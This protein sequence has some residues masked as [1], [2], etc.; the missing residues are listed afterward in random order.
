MEKIYR[1]YK[2][3]G[4][5]KSKDIVDAIMHNDCYYV[6]NYYEKGNDILQRDQ[7]GDTY[8]HI[9]SRNDYFEVID[10]L[11]KLGCDVN[12][13]NNQ[14]ETPLHLATQFNN[15]EA[16]QK[17]LL[18][19]ANPN[20][21]DK[22]G[23]SPLHIAASRG[24]VN[25]LILLLDAGAK[26]NIS[27]S[28]GAKPIHYAVKSG[29]TDMIRHL[30]SS[31]ASLVD[32]DDRKNTVLHYACETNNLNLVN[33]I[34]RHM[35]VNNFKNIYKET[36]VHF[37]ARHGNIEILRNLLN[38]GYDLEARNYLGQSPLDIANITNQENYSFLRRVISG[39]EYKEKYLDPEI[40]RAA[41]ENN[42]EYLLQ[43]VNSE[44][45]NDYDHFGK[46]PIYY[47]IINGN[48]KIVK[49]LYSKGAN[50][51]VVDDANQS[52]LLI[53]VYVEALS[54]IK[55]L[56]EKGSD[57]NEIYYG[58][59]YLYRAILKNNYELVEILVEAGAN[60]NFLDNK[61]RAIFSY[62]IDYAS[63]NIISLLISKSATLVWDYYLQPTIKIKLMRLRRF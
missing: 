57:V 38:H 10:L 62:A 29:K 4:D 44:N 48:L 51:D 13:K 59:S 19:S 15:E 47:A 43:K 22:R 8:L 6:I 52:A 63:D 28:K 25:N 20:S 5:G 56:I 18:E 55:F 7:K 33:Y 16:I 61:H 39:Q 45:V 46:R 11:L 53:A 37:A 14:N 21:L 26:L 60:V 1:L 41:K 3:V 2:N 24:N 17:L 9:A 34:L 31:G 49:F 36:A 27:D 58:R 40:H 42:Y 30:L 35:T 23:V 32:S 54:I 50:I 12:A